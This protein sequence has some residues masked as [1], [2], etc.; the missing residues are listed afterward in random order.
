METYASGALYWDT[1]DAA[2]PRWVLLLNQPGDVDTL[3]LLVGDVDVL[4]VDG[5]DLAGIGRPRSRAVEEC[6]VRIRELRR[7]IAL[8]QDR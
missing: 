2:A 6:A 7:T 3:C 5:D 1:T 8:F 4:V